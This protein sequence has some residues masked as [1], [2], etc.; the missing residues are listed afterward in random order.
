MTFIEEELFHDKG[1]NATVYESTQSILFA[2]SRDG[3]Y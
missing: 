1:L 2:L 3:I